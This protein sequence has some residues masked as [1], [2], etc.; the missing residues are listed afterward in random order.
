M[1]RIKNNVNKAIITSIPSPKAVVNYYLIYTSIFWVSIFGVKSL[2]G[3]SVI[4]G[5][6]GN[7]ILK[8]QGYITW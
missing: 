8:R 6:M 2:K 7:W 1:E 3:I 5:V 4:N